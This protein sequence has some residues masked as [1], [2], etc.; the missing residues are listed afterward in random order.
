MPKIKGKGKSSAFKAS[1]K[2]TLKSPK[3][4]IKASPSKKQTKNVGDF[5]E[6]DAMEP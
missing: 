6:D 2:A 3:K 4:N 1:M 5:E